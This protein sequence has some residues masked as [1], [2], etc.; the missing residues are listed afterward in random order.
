MIQPSVSVVINTVNRAHSLKTALSA[1]RYQH[2]PHFEVVVVNGPSDDDTAK[3][4]RTAGDDIKLMRCSKLNL[5][6]SRNIGISSAA[7]DIIA[8]LDDDAIPEPTWLE[9]LVKIYDDPTIGAAGGP[10]L[11]HTGTAWQVQ[12]TL[13]NRLGQATR[14]DFFTD[15]DEAV[16]PGCEFFPSPTGANSSFRRSALVA[17]GGFDETYAWFLDETD[18]ILRTVDSGWKVRIVKDAI[19]HHKYAESHIRDAS[20]VSKNLF[21]PMLSVAYFSMRHGRNFYGI[22]AAVKR[23]IKEIRSNERSIAYHERVHTYSADKA[24]TMRAQVWAG[25]KAGVRAAFGHPNATR[26]LDEMR[27]PCAP[28]VPFRTVKPNGGRLRICLVSQQYPPGKIGGIGIWTSNLARALAIDGHEVS[29]VCKGEAHTADFIDGVWVHRIIP[30]S[31]P[32]GLLAD[33]PRSMADHANSVRNEVLTIKARRGLD[34]V[35]APIWDLEGEA[36]R[37]EGMIPT[38]TSLHTTYRLSVESK[39]E[40]KCRSNFYNN[41]ILPIISAEDRII[42][43]ADHILANS[44]AI[45]HDVFSGAQIPI[46]KKR[47]RLIQHGLFDT[48]LQTS[49]TTFSSRDVVRVLFVGRL[50]RRKGI[51]VLVYAAD[52]VLAQRPNVEVVVVGEDQNDFGKPWQALVTA[53]E[54]HKPHLARLSFKGFV[55]SR[56][57]D[58][59]YDSCDIFVA[60][61]RYESFGLIYLEAMMHGKPCI[62]TT[63]GG[64]PEVIADGVSGLLVPPSD[65]DALAGAILKLI[66]NQ[67]LRSLYGKAGRKLFVE[68]FSAS[69]MAKDAAEIYRQI[70]I[71]H[72]TAV[73]NLVER[74]TR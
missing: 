44:H 19:V 52:S 25:A 59:Y 55:K 16:Y 62:G 34:V 36:L 13:C 4:L 9:N 60:P 72:Q 7:G 2:Y 3:V 39:P 49:T 8:F 23:I 48:S 11:D 71:S 70:A 31:H 10:I 40:W 33:L 1:L 15:T 20:R 21:Q 5:S 51:D 18:A 17:I 67:E 46:D 65:A 47:V 53:S 22:D 41:H 74:D 32:P 29:V 43:E 35:S 37:R 57:L 73:N 12:L 42:K 63:A 66:D 54:K 24:A 14:P 28:F 26:D 56:E 30:C 68:K 27:E 69:A 61:S 64:I 50:E 45:T 6:V 38:V 58:G